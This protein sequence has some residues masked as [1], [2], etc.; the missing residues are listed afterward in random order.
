MEYNTQ[1]ATNA[2]EDA[3]YT[4]ENA[5]VKGY[6]AIE[7]GVVGGYKKIEDAFVNGWEKVEDACV[8]VLFK[9]EGETTARTKERLGGKYGARQAGSEI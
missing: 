9:K 1:K 4:A 6:R 8:D 7:N 2:A 3:F 5:V